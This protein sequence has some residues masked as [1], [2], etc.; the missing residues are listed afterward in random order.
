MSY[1][2]QSKSDF[3]TGVTLTVKIPEEELD[4]KAL[5]TIQADKPEFIL[6]FHFKSVDGQ[7]ELVYQVGTCSKLQYLS[8]ERL[9]K[10]YTELWSSVFS[11]L[12]NCGDWFMNPYSFMLNAEYLYFDKNKKTICYVYIP[13][14]QGCSGYSDLKEMAAEV[15]KFISIADADLENKVLRA[16]MKDFDPKDFLQMLKSYTAMSA[17]AATTWSAPV[18]TNGVIMHPNAPGNELRIA[19]VSEPSQPGLAGGYGIKEPS[20]AMAVINNGSPPGIP[21]AANKMHPPSAAPAYNDYPPYAVFEPDGS[22]LN[23]MGFDA[24]GDIVINISAKGKPVKKKQIKGKDKGTDSGGKEKGKKNRNKIKEETGGLFGRK[25]TGRQETASAA[26]ATPQ[27]VYEPVSNTVQAYVPHTVDIVDETQCIHTGINGARL[28]FAGSISL[29]SIIDIRLAV[30]GNFTVGRYDAAIGKQQSNFE[31][32][33]K[34]KAVSRRHAVIER[35]EGGYI[36]IDLSSSAGT[37]LNGQKIT[38]NTP[39]ELNHGCHV[40]FGNAGADYIWEN[41]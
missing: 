3:L 2:I 31:F 7:V 28:R 35:H 36:I 16:I 20:S 11:P 39:C 40:S 5:Y 25:S 8:G 17:P 22:R 34:T 41:A 38:P 30:G 33:K 29:P 21:A 6:P 12:L 9:T 18:L 24:P 13:S 27:P 1:E 14:I 37:F 26:A 4:R 23:E 15:T 10:D 19:S 32:D